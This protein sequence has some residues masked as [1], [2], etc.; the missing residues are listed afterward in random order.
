MPMLS[1]VPKVASKFHMNQ[2]IVLPPFFSENSQVVSPLVG[3]TVQAYIHTMSGIRTTDHLF[4][5]SIGVNKRAK[6]LGTIVAWLVRV[7][8]TG[9]YS[10]SKGLAVLDGITALY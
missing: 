3:K 8:H 7:N 6:A 2:E 4:M 5:I 10:K 1:F 9:L